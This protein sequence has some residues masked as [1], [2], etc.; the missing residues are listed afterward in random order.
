GIAADDG[1]GLVT[2]RFPAA[3]RQHHERVAAVE[4]GT[5]R[6]V[7][8]RPQRAEPPG[9]FDD[10]LNV[11]GHRTAP[12]TKSFHVSCRVGKASLLA[13]AHHLRRAW[14][15]GASKLAL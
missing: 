8:Q 3:G 12:G 4:H 11:G 7:L 10:G 5:D 6:L 14:W 2:Q 13:P 9:L 1:G 15:A